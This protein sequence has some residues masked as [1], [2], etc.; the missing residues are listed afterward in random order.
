MTV[1]KDIQEIDQAILMLQEKKRKLLD[2]WPKKA[3]LWVHGDEESV[4]ELGNSLGLVG[5]A[6]DNFNP[7]YELKLELEVFEDG[8]HNILTLDGNPVV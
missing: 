5:A 4:Y 8:S 7:V 1:A 2:A 3:T 6:L